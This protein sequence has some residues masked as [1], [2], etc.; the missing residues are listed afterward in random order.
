MKRLEREEYERMIY[1]EYHVD[2][3]DQVL[4]VFCDYPK[5]GKKQR[6]E[7]DSYKK[8]YLRLYRDSLDCNIWG[9]DHRITFYQEQLSDLESLKTDMIDAKEADYDDQDL[10][11]ALGT[12]F[13]F[14]LILWFVAGPLFLVH[15]VEAGDSGDLTYGFLKWLEDLGSLH[16][17]I[18]IFFLAVNWGIWLLAGI[19]H[20]ATLT[21]FIDIFR[22]KLSADEQKEKAISSITS[23]IEK[24]RNE[25]KSKGYIKRFL[26]T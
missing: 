22:P 6:L 1:D 24:L 11:S 15:L 2:L 12:F 4:E 18:Y 17:A 20:W 10:G 9:E 25:V 23:K 5:K 7:S 8:K 26:N 21:S 19:I 3:I 14:A 13:M 16:W